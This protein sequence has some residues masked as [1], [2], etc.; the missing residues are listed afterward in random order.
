MTTGLLLGGSGGVVNFLD[1][2]LAAVTSGAYFF[3]T[4]E[5]GDSE[6]AKCTAPTLKACLKDR[7]QN[8][9]GNK[10]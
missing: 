10:Q 9:S 4:M 2:Y 3:F 6:F 8:V 1:F 5:D 7:S